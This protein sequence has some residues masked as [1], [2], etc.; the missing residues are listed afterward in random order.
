MISSELHLF[1]EHGRGDVARMKTLPFRGVH[2]PLRLLPG[3]SRVAASSNRGECLHSQTFSRGEVQRIEKADGV[4]EI[5]V[6]CGTLWLTH[7]PGE[8]DIL[9]RASASHSLSTGWPVVVE[10]LEDT[11]VHFIRRSA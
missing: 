11:A 7:T 5:R 3:T 1:S 10:A 9:L 6:I 2:S 4:A 8:G